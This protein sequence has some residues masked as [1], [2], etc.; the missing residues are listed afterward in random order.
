MSYPFAP[1]AEPL[2]KAKLVSKIRDALAREIEILVQSAVAAREGAT[3]EDAK[4]ENDKDTRGIEAGYLAGAQAKRVHELELIA[5]RLEY[6]E[7]RDFR[8][9]DPIAVSALV[10]LELDG[11][12]HRY[13]LATAGGGLKFEVEGVEVQVVTPE[14]PLGEQLVGKIAGDA[15][16]MRAGRQ[17]R[18]Y[19]IVSVR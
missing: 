12:R 7:I 14:A 15:F 16:E 18:E 2:D 10:E 9:G 6:L 5:A 1:V 17:M 19:E 4:P 11:A 13:F 3:H 8:K